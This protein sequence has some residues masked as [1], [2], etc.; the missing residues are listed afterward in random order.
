MKFQE[1]LLDK[2]DSEYADFQ[3]K[4]TPTIPREKFI[5]VRVPDIRAIAKQCVKDEACDE[6]L[7]DLPHKYFEENMLHACILSEIKEYDKAMEYVE[8]FLPYVDN[9]AVCDS[10]IPKVFKKHKSELMAKIRVWAASKESYTCRFGIKMLMSFFLDEDFE[11]EYHEIAAVIRSDEY[12]VNMMVAWYFA[13]ALA[14]QWDGTIGYIENNRL[15]DWTHNKAI[16]KSRESF[17]VSDEHKEY[18]KSLKRNRK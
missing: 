14:K 10:L 4:L 7:R 8:A 2:Q 18:L 1:I 17:R 3:A 11:P 12:Y 16:Q 15:D 6:F 13:T 9:W 5:G